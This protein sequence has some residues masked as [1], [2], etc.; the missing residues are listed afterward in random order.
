MGTLYQ[1]H[2]AHAKARCLVDIL[3]CPQDID[4]IHHARMGVCGPGLGERLAG[5]AEPCL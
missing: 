2:D 4:S 3:P 1:L 5:G